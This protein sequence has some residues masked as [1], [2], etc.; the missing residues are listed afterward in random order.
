MVWNRYQLAVAL[1]FVAAA[2]ACGSD[3]ATDATDAAAGAA[4]SVGR[5]G[6]GSSGAPSMAGAAPAG[7]AGTGSTS[8]AASAGAAGS[9]AGSAGAAGSSS[10]C[11]AR[12]G[13]LFCDDFEA[14]GRT[15]AA[16]WSISA[17]GEGTVT[18][19]DGPFAHSGSKSVHVHGT[20]YQ[21]L[22]AFHDPAVLP[23]ANG[24]FFVR[25]F[26][27][28]GEP[29]TGGHNTF[30]VADTFAAPNAGNALRV[31]EMNAM[32]MMT[33]AGDTHGYLSNQNFYNDGKLGAVIPAEKYACLELLL[34][35]P[36][37]EIQVW[38]DGVTVT[39]LHVTDLAHENYDQL[40]FG[41]EKYAGPVAD[42]WYDDI[43]LGSERVGCN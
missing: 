36:N 9:I 41:F 42:I 29:M 32:L 21:T 43:A 30:L 10:P 8:G 31:G 5:A 23:R 26:L 15:F 13:L 7:S 16:P 17:I 25:A 39:D 20:E 38:L 12:P 28:L 6:A 37:T 11:S 14:T 2:A 18:L 1:G 3:G 27:R 4:G 34:D 40:R 35:A 19:E 33:V 24:R 22:L